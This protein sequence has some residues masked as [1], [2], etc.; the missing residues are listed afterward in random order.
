MRKKT[1]WRAVR[2]TAFPPLGVSAV[3][4]CGALLTGDPSAGRAQAQREI[5]DRVL[6]VVGD[7][8]I[9]Q[10]DVE[11]GVRQLLL[12]Q[13]ATGQPPPDGVNLEK[14]VLEELVKNRLILAKAARLGI[15]VSF[16]EVEKAVDRAIEDNKN[17]LGGERA[18]NRQLEAEGFTLE[19]LRKLYRDQI[20]NRMLV[21]R[22]LAREVDRSSIEVSEEELRLEYEKRKGELPERP[23]V[24]H[25]ATILIGLESSAK[26]RADALATADSLRGRILAGE[27]FAEVAR[28][29]S[30][31]P[32]ADAGGSLG[33]LKLADLGNRAF[34]DAAAALDVGEISQPVLTSFGYH[35]IQVM[36][37][38]TTTGE[39]DLRHIL[40]RVRA[41]D[42]DVQQ[43]YE[44]AQEVHRQL[45]EGGARF[46]STAARY[47][48]DA[49][50][51]AQG[52]DLGWLRVADL[53]DF[54]RDVLREMK[55]G[56]ISP[57][58]REPS[59]FRIV[60]LLERESAR[61]Y[62]FDEVREE[63]EQLLQQDKIEALYQEYLAR[64][65]N[66]FYVDVRA[67]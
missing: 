50:S 45:V 66:E 56:D 33:K 18:F 8:A 32:S 9:F 12:Q 29:Y 62:A 65:R 38:D 34:A 27:D 52:G 61:P 49:A 54:F 10:S 51:A 37:A 63:L 35:L 11:A 60:K 55:P 30:E 1:L 31:D 46:D 28:G 43:V 5:V 40:I 3:L 64:L 36:A 16:S 6:A 17:A 22:V 25:L 20:R 58:L 21:E 14:Q 4:V 39:V 26:A 42:Q 15:S 48:T 67:Q 44:T 59:G 7:E 47:S 41:G 23:E 19:S 53:P 57:V 2:G 13:A 24:V